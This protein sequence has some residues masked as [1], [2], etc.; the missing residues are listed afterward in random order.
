MKKVLIV[1][2]VPS[3]IGQ[4]NMSN[5]QL[6][7][8]QG[9]EIN[10]AA[11]FTDRSVWTEER[12]LQFENQL[13]E[14]GIKKYK[15]DFNRNPLKIK[16]HIISFFQLKK[17]VKANKYIFVHCHTPI[18]GAIVRIVCKL[19]KIKCIY[20][21][22]GFHFYK[23]APIKNWLIYYPI[24]KFLSRYTE[25]L[26]TINKED[27]QRA[28]S[29]FKAKNIYYV[30]GV[31]IDI[32]KLQ[33]KIISRKDKRAELGLKLEEIMLLSVGELSTRKNHEIVI[34]ALAK[35]KNPYIKYFICGTGELK[36]YLQNLVDE[37]RL[38]NNVRFLGYRSDILELCQITDLYIFPS[39][40][41]G[42]PVSLME[43]IGCKTPVICSAIRGNQDLVCNKK[44]M[45]KPTDM[46]DFENC[47]KSKIGTFSREEIR[48]KMQLSVEENISNLKK[49]E[50]KN[51]ER[52]MYRIYKEMSEK[53][54]N[55]M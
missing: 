4:F 19:E 7:K 52:K 15:I 29:K 20:T 34:R 26:I 6:L 50:L 27:Y 17:I 28:K 8:R 10:V 40:Q 25:A 35:I 12:T 44:D 2:T 5:I 1:A 42:L 13:Q 51:V 37:L 33:D 54:Y 21:A 16:K 3:M 46:I 31:G 32:D 41:E 18:A 30:P 47:L 38:H 22:H 53:V 43:A 23:G 45:F 36:N 48:K 11:D 55:E 49:F 14:L 9:C 39:I 24:E